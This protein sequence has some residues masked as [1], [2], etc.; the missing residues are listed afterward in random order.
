MTDLQHSNSFLE[1]L[2]ASPIKAF[3][4]SVQFGDAVAVPEV[5]QQQPADSTSS[6]SACPSWPQPQDGFDPIPADSS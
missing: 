6:T 2:Q 1:A 4:F 5:T 3:T